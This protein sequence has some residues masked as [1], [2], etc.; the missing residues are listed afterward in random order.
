MDVNMQKKLSISLLIIVVSIIVL[1]SVLVNP[2]Q[3]QSPTLLQAQTFT[4]T[5]DPTLTSLSVPNLVS[6]P[7]SIVPQ[8]TNPDVF[9][10]A[11]LQQGL[12]NDD[13]VLRGPYSFGGFGFSVPADW[14]L[15]PGA[16]LNLSIGVSF[17]SE[18]QNQA[19]V[20][21]VGGG[22][23]TVSLND[24]LLTTLSL[25]KVGEVETLIDIPSAAFD[26]AR[27]DGGHVLWF[28]LESSESCRFSGQNT[29]V[30]IH[31]T[32]YFVLPHDIVPPSTNLAN[33]PRPLIQDS[34]TPD[35]A[36]FVIPDQ[37]SAAELQAAFITAAGLGK[38]SSNKMILNMTTVNNFKS[39]D[40]ANS[41]L[42]FVGKAA[43]LSLL[44]RLTLPLPVTEGQF[45]LSSDAPDDG[46]VE[47][48]D[49][50]WSNGPYVALV[51]SGNTDPGI[52]KAAQAVSTGTLRPN[53]VENYSV[54]EK[55]NSI[56][57]S[58]PQVMDR[59]LED[60]GYSG[61]TFENRGFN[62][63]T[64]VF[65]LPVGMTVSPDA[66]FEMIFGH[67]SLL[68]YSNSQIVLYLNNQPIGSVRM[69]DATASL[70]TNHAK[71]MIPP[72]A[73]RP[74]DNYL[75]IGVYM[76]PIEEC[77]PPDVRGLWVNMWPQSIL[78]LPQVA[79]SVD[80]LAPQDLAVYPAP[81]TYTPELSNTAFVLEHNDL[82]SWRNALQISSYLGWQSTGS[83][84]SLA[85]FYGD[86]IPV[87]ERSKYNM[88]VIGRPSQLPIIK[89]INNSMPAPF[90]L[91]SDIASDNSDSQVIFKI[92][93][94]SPRGFIEM[95]QSP[96]NPNNAI[97]AVLGNTSQ[98]VQWAAK[99]L[100]ESPLRSQLRG[101]FA[102][103][104]D[105]Q[106]FTTNSIYSAGSTGEINAVEI[107]SE[108]DVPLG[109]EPAR[110]IASPPAWI[111]PVIGVLIGLMI[112]IVSL[113]VLR[114]RPSNTPRGTASG[115]KR[116]PGDGE[117]LK[118]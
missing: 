81:F 46:L 4:Q 58:N 38:L 65:N 80:P 56:P 88:L 53:K 21:V 1:I 112:L 68:D 67:S 17:N 102:E 40:A 105:Q 75:R 51:V 9:T 77:S 97:L 50:P 19:D 28:G 72:A 64:Y 24:V 27:N 39:E 12:V 66:Y 62:D 108:I 85:A 34:F 110:E 25:N 92:P 98:G 60:L 22:T 89:E 94:D 23:L 48:V 106:I 87:S 118:E 35:S 78:H 31:P 55:I 109:D 29:M 79:K 43:S 84:I 49:S 104:S 7:T 114:R 76:M 70:P 71:I 101:N 13:I 45:Q 10:F 36:L 18:V 44:T 115:D 42:I 15:K 95:M 86:D 30:F 107:P 8:F 59:T 54:I 99:A 69:S 14:V 3:A 91:D 113:V 32:S 93:S 96:W 82:E 57:A 33:F 26:A 2:V 6:T 117:D 20:T 83:V 61:K 103:V 74:G 63:E 16:Q 5:P 11:Q 100:I 111:P 73:V 52:I 116:T 47:M 90:L 41:H 37:P